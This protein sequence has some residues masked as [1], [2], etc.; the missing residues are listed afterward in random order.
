MFAPCRLPRPSS[1]L[2]SILNQPTTATHPRIGPPRITSRPDPL[3]R[4]HCSRRFRAG[5]EV[6]DAGDDR[7]TDVPLSVIGGK[8]VFVKEVQAA[9]QRA[10]PAVQAAPFNLLRAGQTDMLMLP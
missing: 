2:D 7:R 1:P 6:V 4:F 5:D 3:A 10:A 8:G 9:L